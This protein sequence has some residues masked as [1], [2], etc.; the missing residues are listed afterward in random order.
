[1]TRRKSNLPAVPAGEKM[2][3][4][5]HKGVAI[6]AQRHDD[7]ILALT[8]MV[9]VLVAPILAAAG[10]VLYGFPDATDQ[11]WAWPMGPEMTALAVGGGYL[12]GMTVFVRAARQFRWH[13]I[14]VVFPAAAVLTVLLLVA[15]LLHWELFSHE[16]PSFWVWLV[17]YATTPVL[18]PAVWLVNRRRDPGSPVPGTP[19]VPRWVRTV[20]GVAGAAQLTTALVFFVRPAAAITVWPWELSPLTARTVTAF[21][22]FVGVLWLAF[23]V[24]A[25]WSALRLHVEGATIGLALVALG[26]VRARGDF[27]AGPWTTAVFAALLGGVL[28][29]LAL[30]H[31]GMNRTAPAET[32]LGS[33]LGVGPVEPGPR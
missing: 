27:V 33:P 29:G 5:A 11:L 12:A 31:I 8:R 32:T 15:T 1:M 18:L 16:H 23:L 30:L 10:A 17:V 28:A 3:A 13:V 24:E 19:V 7:R 21:L 4:G 9:A 2:P 22:A 14:A 20:V 6:H 26:A 25:R